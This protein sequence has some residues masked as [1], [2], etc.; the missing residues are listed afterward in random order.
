MIHASN[1]KKSRI[2]KDAGT[3]PEFV[4]RF[5][6]GERERQAGTFTKITDALGLIFA[7][8]RKPE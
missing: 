1:L 7:P 3:N 6:R 8:R 4:A 2:G 5:L